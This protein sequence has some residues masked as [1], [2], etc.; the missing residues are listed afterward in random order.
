MK[1]KEEA[2][3]ANLRDAPD[4]SDGQ[5]FVT[6][7][8]TTYVQG[9]EVV[10]RLDPDLADIQRKYG[11][12]PI[13]A[14]EPGFAT[15][16]KIILEQQVSLSSAQAAFNRLGEMVSPLT[17]EGLLQLDDATLKA[18]G[19][20]RQKTGYARG[21][22]QDIL[23]GR[24]DVN[25]LGN[26]DDDTVRIALMKIKGIGLWSADIYLLMVLKRADVWP[27]GDLALATLMMRVKRLQT[28]PSQEEMNEISRA[29]QPW[30]AV[31]ARFLWHDYLSRNG[32]G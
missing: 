4:K 11:P 30:R 8:E 32:K 28:I 25:A 20:S 14:R 10:C 15:L 6:L 27:R 24:L 12:P 31:A 21:L 19:F 3:K 9:I 23:S 1:K 2:T 5:V 22:A 26:M 7:D 17:P 18:Y 29:W 13:W 16:V